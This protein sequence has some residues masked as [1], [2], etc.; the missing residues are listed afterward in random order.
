MEICA[1]VAKV[2]EMSW[3]MPL[4]WPWQ[5]LQIKGWREEDDGND[6][7]D[8]DNDDDGDNNDGIDPTS[9]VSNSVDHEPTDI[10]SVQMGDT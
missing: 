8:D 10:L 2:I 6:D 1:R 7:D 9:R 3:L 4:S 5:R